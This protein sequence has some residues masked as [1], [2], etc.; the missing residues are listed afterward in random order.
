MN[1][2]VAGQL[3]SGPGAGHRVGA[4]RGGG[5]HVGEVG[6]GAAGQ[7]DVGV[8]AVL[9]PGDH[10]QAGVHRAALGDMIGDRIPEFGIAE[11]LVQESAVGPPALPGGRVGVQGAA[12]DQPARG[13]GLDAQ[14]VPVGQRPAGFSRLERCGRCGCR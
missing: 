6:V 2:V 1:L 8:L 12:H 13:D 5:E 9:G 4:L 7:R 10:R 14:Q 11:M 3:G